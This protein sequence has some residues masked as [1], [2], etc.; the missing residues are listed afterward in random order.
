MNYEIWQRGV[1]SG[2]WQYLQASNRKAMPTK[3]PTAK[4]CY[5]DVRTGLVNTIRWPAGET[6]RNTTGGI[7]L[8]SSDEN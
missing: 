3:S 2:N 6:T 4:P 1:A 7:A 5:P 8:N